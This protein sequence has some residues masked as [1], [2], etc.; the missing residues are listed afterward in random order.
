MVK[1]LTRSALIT[2]SRS[3]ASGHVR[4]HLR[5]C[6]DCAQ[7]A[8]LYESFQVAGEPWLSSAPS[9]W[10]SKAMAING[11]TDRYGL[12]KRLT[13]KLSFDSWAQNLVLGV[14]GQVAD[15]RRVRFDHESVS[16]DI[17]AEKR[18]DGWRFIGRL[19]VAREKLAETALVVDGIA[20]YPEPSGFVDWA[21][22]EPPKT[23]HIA[24][25]GYIVDIPE[26]LWVYHK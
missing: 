11:L 14:R 3:T 16:A 23:M 25:P 4:R 5:T 24:L 19:G 9:S 18:T 17:R 10:T 21:A 15:E 13:A 12:V 7:E 8:A 20:I 22:A 6:C 1:H 26:L 2:F